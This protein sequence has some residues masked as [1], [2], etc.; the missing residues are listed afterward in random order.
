MY[1]MYLIR[2]VR[3]CKKAVVTINIE[4]DIYNYINMI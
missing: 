4:K 1:Y 3:F 2:F